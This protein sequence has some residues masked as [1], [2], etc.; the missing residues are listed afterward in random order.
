[1]DQRSP[2]RGVIAEVRDGD[3]LLRL[4]AARGLQ[5]GDLIE[6]HDVVGADL[7]VDAAPIVT[8]PLARVVLILGELE[9]R[10]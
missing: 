3:F 4:H 5:R 2:A 6:L 9:R 1:M 7:P 10:T 8:V